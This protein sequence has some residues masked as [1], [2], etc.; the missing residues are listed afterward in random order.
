MGSIAGP[1]SSAVGMG[2][3][4]A[5]RVVLGSWVAAGWAGL[6]YGVFLTVTALRSPPGAEL[7]GQ[8]TGQPALKASMA[9]LLAFAAAAHPIV[10]ERRWLMLALVFSAAG[11]ALLAIPW[12]TASF[13]LGLAA[14][15]LAHLCFLGVLA[16]LARSSG[17][18]RPRPDRRCCDVRGVRG[19][20]GVV[21]AAPG[22][23]RVDGSRHGL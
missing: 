17:R 8:W 13:V 3:P 9:L 10:R 12:W 6:A 22:S 1:E 18:S 21:L 23:R 16:P 15:L 2:T 4:Y 11:D 19:A 7:T 20:A 5:S 14:F